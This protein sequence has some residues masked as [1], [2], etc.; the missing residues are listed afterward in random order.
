MSSELKRYG[1]DV[2]CIDNRVRVHGIKED[3][4]GDYYLCSEV[5]PIL[6]NLREEIAELSAEH[7][8]VLDENTKQA[9]TIEE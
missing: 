5:D 9:Q 2:E 8:D 6:D 3:V 7:K 1:Y 4:N